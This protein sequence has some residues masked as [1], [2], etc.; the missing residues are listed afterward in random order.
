MPITTC[1][2]VFP[3]AVL[4]LLA[5]IAPVAGYES[6]TPE[7]KPTLPLES[8][9]MLTGDWV[10]ADTHRIDFNQLPRIAS[11]HVVISDVHATGGVNQ[12]NYLVHHAGR[13]W[14]MWS[15]GP[16]IED[17]VGQRVKYATSR[18]GRQWSMPR[19]LTPSPPDSGPD[20]PYYNTRDARGSRWISRG[21]W[22][23]RGTTAGPGIPRRS[24]WLF[25]K[26]SGTPRLPLRRGRG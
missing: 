10:P 2:A 9:P 18:D 8:A 6:P 4:L 1:Q 11:E 23:A 17:R 25:R 16:G 13:F 15:D 3:C 19:D 26:E 21:F 24:G 5:L 12:H 20:S 7:A 22:Q 14:V